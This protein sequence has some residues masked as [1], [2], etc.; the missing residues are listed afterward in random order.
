MI[1]KIKKYSFL[2]EEL[3][4]RDFKQKY[5]RTSLGILWS[6]LNPLLTLLIMSLIFTQFFG[7]NTPNY[8]I[9]LFCGN[10]VFSYFTDS[11]NGGMTSL[12]ANAGIITK[13]NIPKYLFLLAKNVSCLI[14]FGLTLIILF[15]FVAIDGIA[16]NWKFI[17][18]LYPIACL[19][20]F[21]L[22]MGLILS[23]L[24]VIFRDVQYLYAI[25]TRLLMYL[26]A[27]F[28]TIDIYPPDIQTLFY[29][30]PVFVYI[31][32]FRT[33]I[34]D[35]RI[36]SIEIHLLAMGYAIAAFGI[37]GFIYKKYNHKFIYYM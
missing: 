9:Y 32:Y 31:D 17:M 4:K 14:N 5:K 20:V 10:L 22:G 21:N 28:Y 29:L 30:N 15:V 8:I 33:I 1:N 2:F 26:S 3:V 25:F 27:I 6:L 35:G 12:T 16:F 36:P 24:F 37:G 23:A 11:T 7:R 13:I 18:L 34:I 19:L